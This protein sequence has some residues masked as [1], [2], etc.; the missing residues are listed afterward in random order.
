MVTS[1]VTIGIVAHVD[2][3]KQ[4]SDLR[5]QVGAL[6]VSYDSG[7][8]GC[9]ANHLRVWERLANMDTPWVLVLE[10][11]AL[12]VEGFRAQLDMALAAAPSPVVSLYLGTS[13]PT[14]WQE[15]IKRALV[16]RQIE[17]S[18]WLTCR[19]MLHAV[20]VAMRTELIQNMLASV[21][22]DAAP[23]DEAITRWVKAQH[24][25]VSYTVPS[26]CDHADWPTLIKTHADRKPRT[27]PRKAW[28]LGERS[29]WRSGTTQLVY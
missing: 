21:R 11:D 4:A 29:E 14:N 19:N 8:L 23:I 1:S 16:K 28:R 10:D 2:R 13:N 22:H 26:L 24:L 12:P 5:E 25:S 3:F 17:R 27:M 9:T 15:P 7:T 6:H 18:H 20:A